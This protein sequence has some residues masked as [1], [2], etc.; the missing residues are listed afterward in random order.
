MEEQYTGQQ[1]PQNL[2]QSQNQNIISNFGGSVSK[3]KT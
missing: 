3:T 1:V 2:M